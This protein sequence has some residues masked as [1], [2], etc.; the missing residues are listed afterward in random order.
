MSDS[1][2]CGIDEAG[3]GPLAGP[4][5]AAAVILPAGFPLEL[6]ADSKVLTPARRTRSAAIIRAKAVAWAV[7]WAW[8]EEIDRI[9]I[10]HATLLAMT[11]AVLGLSRKPELLLVDGLFTPVIDIPRRAIVKGDAT[12]PQIM[13]ASI[14]AKT[15]R[16]TWMD[17]YSRIEPGYGFDRH[18]G[19]P[20][21]EHR[22]TIERLGPSAIHRWSFRVSPCG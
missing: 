5:T 14:L 3:R 11:R 19:Y 12:V 4:V 13:A 1:M 9:N 18:K 6:L 8:P 20:T 21:K 17:R 22:R 2:V 7:G 16:D 10:H 15:A